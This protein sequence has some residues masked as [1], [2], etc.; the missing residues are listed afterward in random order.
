MCL[1][2]NP[3]I[4]FLFSCRMTQL[5][6]PLDEIWLR[7]DHSVRVLERLLELSERQVTA[8][9]AHEDF[10][11]ERTP[12]SHGLVKVDQGLGEL[13]LQQLL[14]A[15]FIKHLPVIVLKVSLEI[16]G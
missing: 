9:S 13:L 2:L 7:V 5:L 8:A 3:L 6:L 10:V 11:V 1:V 12:R 14:K 16:K 15:K 4:S